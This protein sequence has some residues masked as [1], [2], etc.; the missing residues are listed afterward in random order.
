MKIKIIV[1]CV[2]FIFIS[3]CA[4]KSPLVKASQEGDAFATAKLIRE[5][6]NVDETDESG[7][8]PLMYATWSGKIDVVKILINQGADINKRDKEGYTPLLWASS[9]GYLDIAKL[10]ID[11]GSDVNARSNDKNSPLLLAL[12]ANNHELSSLLINKGADANVED[13]NGTTPLIQA[14]INGDYEI[15]KMLIENGGDL[16][17]V[18]SSGYKA[19]DYAKFSLKTSKRV[20]KP[21]DYERN[22]AF[23]DLIKKS[24]RAQI[25]AGQMNTKNPKLA[26]IYSISYKVGKCI[27]PDIDYDVFIS[28][29]EEPNAWVN[30]SGNLTFT[31]EALEKYDDDILVFMAAHE[32][33]HDKLGHVSKKIAVSSTIT[34]AMIVANVLLPGAGLLNHIINPTITNNY[35]K[36]Q[37]YDA[38]QLASDFC[39]K[40][41]GI[42][43]EK[44]IAIMQNIKRISKSSGGGF[45][46]THP[47]WNDRIKNIAEVTTIPSK[48]SDENNKTTNLNI[49]P[50]NEKETESHIKADSKYDGIIGIVLKDGN[51]IE[52]KIINM[53]ANYVTVRTQ[54]G[55]IS[56]YSFE[57]EV[58]GFVK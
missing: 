44:Q 21:E 54:D 33:A 19:S 49:S 36:T 35:S 42:S 11:R 4:V 1:V 8:T 3:G 22:L 15:A 56:S 23:L 7:H 39:V 18:D 40:C 41:F 9:Y 31:K 29:K 45:W 58:R 12:A 52:G 55:K 6:V 27:N 10:L 34:G 32:I 14:A 47:S 13:S 26:R 38:D 5:G 2:F 50:Q 51:V 57:K 43:I 46:A 25:L 53:N 16:F 24:E 37:E 28:D 48:Q 17:A 20:F 30:V